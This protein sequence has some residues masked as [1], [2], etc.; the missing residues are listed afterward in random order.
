[1]F[2]I[3]T[4]DLPA[5]TWEVYFFTSNNQTM[6][7]NIVINQLALADTKLDIIDTA[8]LD[9]V[10]IYCSS[11]HPRIEKVRIH[12]D[13]GS[14]TWIDLLTIIDNLP[15][16]RITDTTSIGKRLRTIERE[17]FITLRFG[18]GKR[19]YCRLLP[20]IDSVMVYTSS[21]NGLDNFQ[22]WSRPVNN[23][24][25]D[26]SNK[27]YTSK[28]NRSIHGNGKTAMPCPLNGTSP[29]KAKYPNGHHECEEYIEEEEADRG[30]K[31][32]N[33]P[34]QYANLHKILRAGYGFDVMSRTIKEVERKYGPGGWDYATLAAWI[35]KGGGQDGH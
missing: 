29:L 32:I 34:K 31:F 8:I 30:R 6:K 5:V 35:E 2:D 23:T 4:S 20:K 13:E 33:R 26:Y 24:N 21:R 12:D 17:G 9:F 3:I 1:M 19:L 14:W 16:L 18:A 25:K 10:Y 7:Y 27:D 15:L 11:V 28:D 22:K